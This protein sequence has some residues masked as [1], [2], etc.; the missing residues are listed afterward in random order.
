MERNL[1][2]SLQQSFSDLGDQVIGFLPELVIAILIV[3][4]GWVLGGL[5]K[6]VVKTLFKTF[7]IT[8]AL[9][10]AGVD[11]LSERAGY[12]FKPAEFVGSLIEWFVIIVFI[13]VALDVLGL[14]EV[15]SFFTVEILTYIPRVIVASLILLGAMVVARLVAASVAATARAAGFQTADMIARFAKYSILVFAVLA[16][17]NQLQI[18]T[19]LVQMLFAGFV[20]GVSL[21]FGLAF[22][23]GGRETASRYL[24]RITRR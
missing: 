6:G 18:A 14:N 22:G 17:L 9:D 21:A 12:R 23:L 2:T 19:E 7:N 1:G 16:A 5:L 20:F 24:E 8:T 15:T 13:V 3:V 4:V 11:T 10:K